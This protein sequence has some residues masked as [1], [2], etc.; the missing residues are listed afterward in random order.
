MVESSLRRS[1]IIGLQAK[2]IID[3]I[4]GQDST[5]MLMGLGFLAK[6]YP[7]IMADHRFQHV[8]AVVSEYFGESFKRSILP[9]SL[10][11]P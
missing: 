9:M 8:Q 3:K 5:V 10:Q 1:S 7:I 2:P 11:N 6:E 4:R